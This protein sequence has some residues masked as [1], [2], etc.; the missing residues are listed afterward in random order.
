MR[1]FISLVT[2]FII[3]IPKKGI[4]LKLYIDY[5][6]FNKITKKNYIALLFIQEILDRLSLAKIFI[7]LDLKN[8][9]YCVQIKQG[10][11]E[12]TAFR[13]KYRYYEFLIILIKLTNTLTIFQTYINNVL[14]GLINTIYIVYVDNIIIYSKNEKD[15]YEYIK[16]VF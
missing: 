16:E 10:N 6:T 7:K 11:E 9:Y 14:A 1:L 13:T 3:F 15:Y 4:K 8:I 5:Y 12:K 2:V